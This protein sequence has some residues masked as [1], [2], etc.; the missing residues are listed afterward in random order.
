MKAGDF[1][2]ENHLLTIKMVCHERYWM[3]TSAFLGNLR[4]KVQCLERVS[5]LLDYVAAAALALFASCKNCLRFS[6][7]EI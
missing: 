3:L 1:F 6:C 4:N 2:Q 5:C 7:D